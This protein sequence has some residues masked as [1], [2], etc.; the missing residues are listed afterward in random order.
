MPEIDSLI[1]PAIPLKA[2]PVSLI[3]LA[4]IDISA[5]FY[6]D[7]EIFAR[8]NPGKCRGQMPWRRRKLKSNLSLLPLC[9]R[10][11]DFACNNG[12]DKSCGH[13]G[14]RNTKDKVFVEHKAVEYKAQ[15]PDNQVYQIKAFF[16]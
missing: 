1:F 7:C 3:F 15:N 14:K 6:S 5:L 11:P 10:Y 4:P 9:Y 12:Q 8:K 2:E 16:G 13:T